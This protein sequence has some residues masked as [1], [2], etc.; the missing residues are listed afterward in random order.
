SLANENVKRT[1]RNTSRTHDK[2]PKKN[3]EKKNGH[4]GAHG[5]ISSTIVLLSDELQDFLKVESVTR[6]QA[7]KRVWEYIK[8][9]NLQNPND[10]REILCDSL[11]EP[12]FGKKVTMFTLNKIL[13]RNMYNQNDVIKPKPVEKR[14]RD[15]GR[16]ETTRRRTR[17]RTR[18]YSMS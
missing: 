15:L 12:I 18:S 11:M 7:V 4:T 3:V 6:T 9:N 13:A 16:E 8:L 14:K 2:K 5:G 1:T 10:R 17:R